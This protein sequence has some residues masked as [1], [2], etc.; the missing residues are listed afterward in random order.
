MPF[1]GDDDPPP[2]F[3][4]HEP[5]PKIDADTA[6][7]AVEKGALIIDLGTPKDWLVAHIPGASLVE[8]E[9]FDLEFERIPKERPIVVAGRDQ[10]LAEEI[11]ASMRGK[12]WDAAVLE[13]GVA[14]WRAAGHPLVRADGTPA[15]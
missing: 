11:V 14:A 7:T 9:L 1:W 8:P 13:G 12:G 10:G 2:P 3:W 15:R 5:V 4:G 6:V